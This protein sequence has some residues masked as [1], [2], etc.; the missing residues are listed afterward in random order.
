MRSIAG[1]PTDCAFWRDINGG[2]KTRP[3]PALPLDGA[4]PAALTLPGVGAGAYRLRLDL[5]GARPR[6]L[7]RRPKW[8]STAGGQTLAD[9]QPGPARASYEVRRARRRHGAAAICA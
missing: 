1:S 4:R 2:E 7:P 8:W 5:N 3:A 6:R 9:L